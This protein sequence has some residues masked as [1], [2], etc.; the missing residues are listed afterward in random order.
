[1]PLF[2]DRLPF[3]CWTDRTRT[4]LLEY[5]SAEVPIIVSERDASRPSPSAHA[6]DW[7]IDTGNRGVAFAW[8]HHLLQ[9]GLDPDL[10]HA[11]GQVAIVTAM[12]GRN[13]VPI[14]RA[15]LWL[16]SNLP[17]LQGAP[18]RIDMIPGIPFRDV[19]SLPDPHFHR[20][21]IG[22]RTLRRARLRVELDCDKNTLSVWTPDD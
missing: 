18:W 6:D 4:P 13:L 21:L 9:F 12:G 15:S 11:P 7:V 1:V 8:R 5:W 22:L 2:I 16:V 19:P 17:E 10:R 3:R 14:R 20:P